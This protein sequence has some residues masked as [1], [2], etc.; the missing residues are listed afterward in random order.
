[1]LTVD[2]FTVDDSVVDDSIVEARDFVTDSKAFTN[3][4]PTLLMN[5][6]YHNKVK[7]VLLVASDEPFRWRGWVCVNTSSV[8]Y[9]LQFSIGR[10]SLTT[11]YIIVTDWSSSPNKVKINSLNSSALLQSKYHAC[12][13]QKY[14]LLSCQSHSIPYKYCT[15]SGK[16]GNWK[17]ILFTG[18]F[19]IILMELLSSSAPSDFKVSSKSVY[20]IVYL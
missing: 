7:L 15:H 18:K 11:Q 4:N 9:G 14:Y 16:R 10:T 12:M 13:E 3:I 19:D 1:M 17:M 8:L 6:S 2:R 5:I 20:L